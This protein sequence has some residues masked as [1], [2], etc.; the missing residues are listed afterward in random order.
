LKQY[1][2]DYGWIICLKHLPNLKRRIE[3]TTTGIIIPE[4]LIAE[5]QEKD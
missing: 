2:F 1:H 5:S 3:T 4:T